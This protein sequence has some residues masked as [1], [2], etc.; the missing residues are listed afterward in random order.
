MTWSKQAWDT[1]LPVYNKILELPF[2]HQLMDG[3]LAHRNFIFYIQ[4]DALYLAA[5]GKMLIGLAMR[6]EKPAHS[7][8]FLRFAADSMYVE[9]ELHASFISKINPAELPA[10]WLEPSPTCQLYTSY[11][12][13]L[14]AHAPVEAA[15]GGVLPCFWIYKEVGDYI[16]ANRRKGD[17]P[18]QQ[19]IDTYGGDEYGAAVKKAIAICDEVA[20]QSDEE[21]RQAM[22]K[23]YLMC[24][25]M[26]WMFW[27][28]ASR[29]EQ[30]PV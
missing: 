4:Q 27:D 29:L 5:Y 30:W 21:R 14:V 3:T 11:L 13:Q 9:H 23:A 12:L 6:L 15:L 7:E 8:A 16:L 25:K 10:G 28:S 26:E 22:S 17:N 1:A 20:A 19:W 18:Y 24:S 2:I